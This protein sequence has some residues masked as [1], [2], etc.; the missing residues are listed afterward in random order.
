MSWQRF[1]LH[2]TF[3]VILTVTGGCVSQRELA[4][5]PNLYSAANPYPDL[6]LPEHLRRTQAKLL[7]FTDRGSDTQTGEFSADRSKSVTVGTVLVDF[8][9]STWRDI[10]SASQRTNLESPS[11]KLSLSAIDKQIVF[12]ETPI[13][14]AFS[15]GRIVRDAAIG[16]EYDRAIS[17]FRETVSQ[18]LKMSESTSVTVFVHGFNTSFED[19]AFSLTDIWHYSGRQSV[20]LLFSWPSKSGSLFGYLADRESGEFSIFHLK[21]LFRT[22][23]DV[24]GLEQINVL[25]HSRGT[26]ITTSALRELVI[27]AR[28]A[29]KSPRNALK[30]D[31]LIL[32]APDLDLAVVEQ[33]LI[34]EQFGPAM[35]Q[36]TIYTNPEDSALG[37]SSFISAG[38]R[39]GRL[40]REDLE[41]RVEQVFRGVKNVHFV[42]P[43]HVSGFVGHSYY[44]L[45]PGVLADIS[46]I[47]QTGAPPGSSNRPLET[48]AGNY[49][50]MREGYQPNLDVQQS[51]I[52]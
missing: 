21:E 39:F 19:A 50:L 43:E 51:D 6:E 2:S 25:A 15:E 48:V 1:V 14:F 49:M 13:P 38:T 3:L 41:G 24:E 32:A 46:V 10:V 45:H 29:G 8:D 36:I 27:E 44:R 18:A 31:S 16:A 22:L 35:G 42:T 12:P 33:R 5:A 52:E 40:E 28:A 7:F 4:P 47:F 37:L 26:D 34:A 17:E 23:Q 20:P 30:I 9:N 11:L